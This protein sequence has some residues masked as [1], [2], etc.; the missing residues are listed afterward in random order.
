LDSLSA[1]KLS[2]PNTNPMAKD[3]KIKP[4][5]PKADQLAKETSI[6]PLQAQ[7]LIN[8]GIEDAQT[9]KEFLNPRLSDLSNPME[10]IDMDKAVDLI[11]EVL[12]Q[13]S[14]L[15]V[16]GDYDADGFTATA[17]L[18][19]FFKDLGV[20]VS[21]YIPNRMEEGYSLN[22]K[23]IEKL[24]HKGVKLII[25]VDCGTTNREEIRLAQGMGVKIIVTDHHKVGAD[26]KPIC[27]VINP[28]RQGSS[29][30][31]RQ[32]AGVGVAF[33]LIV[34]LRTALR[35][36]DWFKNRPEPDLRQ[37][38]DL[39]AIGTIADMV[40]L[41]DQNRIFVQA[42]LERIKS[43]MWEGIRALSE[44]ADIDPLHVT[45]NDLAFRLAPRLNA[46]GRLGQQ[47]AGIRILLEDNAHQAREL[48]KQLNSLNFQRQSIEQEIIN[49]IEVIIDEN[50]K[51]LN[52][53]I[54]LFCEAGW[55]Q[56]VLGIVASRILEKYHRP[57]LILTRLNGLAI[58]S[59]RS[60]DGFDLYQALSRLGHLFERFGG[61]YHAAGFALKES[62]LENLSKKLEDL[63]EEELREEDLLPS[64]YIDGKLL[65]EDIDLETIKQIESLA[66]FG[67]GNQPP[68][69]YN[70]SLEVVSSWI[71]GEKHL[72]MRV[73]QGEKVH[74][75]IAFG[76]GDRH[77]LTGEKIQMAFTPELNRWQGQE[78]IQLKVADLKP[79]IQ[80]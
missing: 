45:P 39:V 28:H 19:H 26:F 9:V 54:F 15:A 77:P 36:R 65:L 59:G 27:P 13:H 56:G 55:H 17:I 73:R 46:A 12:D 3:W 33:L 64:L 11:L 4:S 75:A 72:K 67:A 24:A 78:K 70:P 2:Y 47:Q 80:F 10:L 23:A 20:S 44:V 40:P 79:D 38:L 22:I 8:R 53:R 68:L 41:I 61:H 48:A 35:Q 25:T 37:Y 52:R 50:Q 71:V 76:L 6:S 62:N 42:G 30:A 51:I 74:E 34:A 66:P 57:T 49:Q 29:F 69:F 5:S 18:H 14:P 21:H 7:L 16:Y 60:I 63:A 58:G 31:F 32:L 1:I 43:S